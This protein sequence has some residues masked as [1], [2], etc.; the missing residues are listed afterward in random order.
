[1]V[2]KAR[3]KPA[4]GPKPTQQNTTGV[5]TPQTSPAPA[6]GANN[7]GV[8]P[9][10][11]NEEGLLQ[12]AFELL[13]KGEFQAL[14]QVKDSVLGQI[15]GLVGRSGGG[16]VAQ[17][18]G[19][20]G[21]GAV[22]VIFPTNVIDLIPGAGKVVSG[23]TK[24]LKMAEKLG[25]EAA[26]KVAKEAAQKSAKEAAENSAKQAAESG[27]KKANVAGNRGGNNKG[28]G[29]DKKEKDKDPCKHE[30]DKKNKKYVVYQ[31][32]EY[33]AL[34]N[35]LGTYVG[36]TSGAPGE[37]S[38]LI[39]ARRRQGHHRKGLEDDLKEVFITDRYAAVRGAEQLEIEA[40]RDS[41]KGVKQI[42]GVSE[43]NKAKDDYLD[44]AKLKGGG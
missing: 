26:Q 44:C 4:K 10:T 15:D 42:N 11:P 7:P 23:G 22:E 34:G 27:A 40:L 32:M 6:G 19:A 38:E 24:A 9:Q 29:K 37:R 35:P 25:K 31:A 5:I 14:N 17:L 36:R 18:A 12:K 1:M 20:I 16:A 3:P 8:K 30:N 21:K 33:D 28:K 39:L 43:K 2:K 13:E 41:G